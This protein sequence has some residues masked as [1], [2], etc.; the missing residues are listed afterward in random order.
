MKKIN[1]DKVLELIK[2]SN[3]QVFSTV[4]VKKDGTERSMTC[5]LGVKK[6]LTGLGMKYEPVKMGLLPVYDMHS[7]GYR[8][9]NLKTVKALQIDKEFY[10]V[11]DS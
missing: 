8:M 11:G 10:L 2:S 9:I 1:R 3:G 5:R 4:F 6:H 7:K